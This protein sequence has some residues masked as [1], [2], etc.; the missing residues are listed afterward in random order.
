MSD[1]MYN[2]VIGT[3]SEGEMTVEI[4]ESAESARD[5]ETNTHQPLQRS[6]NHIHYFDRN[7]TVCTW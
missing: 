6:G 5:K 4:Y 3:E 1:S 7:I 2:D